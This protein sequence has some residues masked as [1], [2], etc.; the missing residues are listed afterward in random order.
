MKRNIFIVTFIALSLSMSAQQVFEQDPA[1]IN[2]GCFR[3]LLSTCI[4]TAR[5]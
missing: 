4:S 3:W 2:P 1:I 5:F